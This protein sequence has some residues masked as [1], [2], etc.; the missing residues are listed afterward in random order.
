[1][2]ARA[3]A[4]LSG[5]LL[6][7]IVVSVAKINFSFI[8]PRSSLQ[9]A[10]SS[11]QTTSLSV[12]IDATTAPSFVESTN[13]PSFAV[14][15]MEPTTNVLCDEMSSNLSDFMQPLDFKHR[16]TNLSFLFPTP[17][18]NLPLTEY[19]LEN[20][21][22]FV[23]IHINK[24]GGTLFKTKIL[25]QAAKQYKWDGAGFGALFGWQRLVQGC[26]SNS[27]AKQIKR[28]AASTEAEALACGSPALLTPCGPHNGGTCPLRVL[29]GSHAL[30]LCQ[31]APRG[32]PCI[33]SVV[34]RHPVDRLISHYNY[35]C[36][37]GSE[38][39]KLW[40]LE[41]KRA[42]RCP[43][44]LLQFMERSEDLSSDTFLIDSLALSAKCGTRVA[45]QNLFHPCMRY[46]LLDRLSDGLARLAAVWGPA[47]RPYLQQVS[48]SQVAVNVATYSS[49]I[50]QQIGDENIMTEVRHR[51]REDIAF[52]NKA[53]ER[54][55]QQW[56]SP[57]LSC[58]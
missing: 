10:H 31:L 43:L 42:N 49:R 9:F 32:T 56:D 58:V 26:S 18:S 14:N 29:W 17:A 52:Y 21:A 8:P 23:F 3:W 35:V 34:L 50:K 55:E 12:Y 16:H 51:L 53:V 11:V 13:A 38:G 2:L 24:A 36:I 47:M 7:F 48:E 30:P 27:T 57:L 1:M 46:L 19:D 33:T 28:I 25:H 40:D 44:T 45:L 5:A 15:S 37:E 6:L 54:Y 20:R 41:W 22:V 39:K 4:L